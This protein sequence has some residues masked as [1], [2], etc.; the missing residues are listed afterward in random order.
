MEIATFLIDFILNVDSHLANFVTH[1]G[2]WVY[3]LLFLIVF[4]ETGVVVMPF[5]PG[6][7]LL[8]VVGAL[9]GAGLI[10]YPLACAI[11]IAAAAFGWV[12]AMRRP[13]SGRSPRGRPGRIWSA[14]SGKRSPRPTAGSS[15]TA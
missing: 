9:A 5:L 12:T 6:D 15:W 2:A 4:V 7:S 1:Y 3:A 10:D 11:L 14:R 8:F 13:A